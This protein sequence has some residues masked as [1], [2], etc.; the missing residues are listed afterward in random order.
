MSL[1]E[2]KTFVQDH[3]CLQTLVKR[4]LKIGMSICLSLDT[5]SVCVCG[6]GGGGAGYFSDLYTN[7][8]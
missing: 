7:C 5:M 3:F 1:K 2:H 8:I 6:V 4:R